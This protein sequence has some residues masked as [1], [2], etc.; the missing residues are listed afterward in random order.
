MDSSAVASRP[1]YALVV[2]CIALFVIPLTITGSGV[3]VL[4]IAQGFASSYLQTQ[5]VICSFMV[6][7]AA[8]MAMTGVMADALG[9]KLSFIAGLAL[10]AIASAAAAGAGS[11]TQLIA[12]RALTGVGAA[13]VTTAGTAILALA[14]TGPARVRA[15]TVFGTA[16]G[17][18]LAVGPLVAG[19]LVSLL[20]SWRPFFAVIAAVLGMVALLGLGLPE[21][22]SLE[23]QAVDW[24]GGVLFTSCLIL[25][26]S[27]F[28]MV[29]GAGWSDPTV[30]CLFIGAALLVPVFVKVES[31]AAH[32]IVNLQLLRNRQFLAVC[33]TP[34]FLGFG[35]IS[36]LF[37]LPQ[38]LTVVAGMSAM[39][40]GIALMCSTLP[41]LLLPLFSSLMRQQLPLRTL[42]VV[43]FAFM[44]LGPLS[45]AWVIASPTLLNLAVPLFIT[46]ASFGVSLSYLDGAAV[47]VVPPQRSGMAAG[48]FNTFRLGGE[49]LTI[50]LLGMVIMAL[51]GR[52]ADDRDAGLSVLVQG[53]LE[54]AAR[55][56]SLP[57]E[58][59]IEHLAVAMQEALIVIS[60]VSLV[61]L[62]I[63]L[64]LSN[65]TLTKGVEYA[66]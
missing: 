6:S 2:V 51:L 54:R 11:L 26:V 21:S 42:M 9:R 60:A 23:R 55:L 28:S 10:F 63:I 16:L 20:Y 35:Y 17:L 1:A 34:V 31:R 58:V 22:R 25:L 15:F 38:Y 48:M 46:G 65:Q 50:P 61:G 33:V 62:M 19:S 30:L 29:P 24:S 18:G 5:W 64:K 49:A 32:P 41:S 8:F 3:L 12:A 40:I 52:Q 13:A 66:H 57:R 43:T 4:P 53:D 7:Y 37:Y 59:L 27:A 36:L 56:L 45:L 47:S 44:V 39:E 14:Y